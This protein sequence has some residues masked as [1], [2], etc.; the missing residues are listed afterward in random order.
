MC[1]TGCV[2]YRRWGFH[3]IIVF[4]LLVGFTFKLLPS[5][6]FYSDLKHV[7]CQISYGVISV[8]HDITI[9]PQI[10]LPGHFVLNKIRLG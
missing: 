3:S 1:K 8:F 10:P 5:I 4:H 6:Y 9:H 2:C 7:L